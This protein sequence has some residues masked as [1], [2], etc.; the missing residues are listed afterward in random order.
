MGK[1][2]A[3]KHMKKIDFSRMN[4]KYFEYSNRRIQHLIRSMVYV[5]GYCWRFG[6]RPQGVGEK[7]HLMQGGGLEGYK[8]TLAKLVAAL[9]LP[10]PYQYGL[11]VARQVMIMGRWV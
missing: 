1:M 3:V 7:V 10:Y 6:G 8:K 2:R 11:I 4:P 9:R 5:P